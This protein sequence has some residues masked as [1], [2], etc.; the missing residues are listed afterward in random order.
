MRG[1]SG[2]PNDHC[3]ADLLFFPDFRFKGLFAAG[4]SVGPFY[5]EMPPNRPKWANTGIKGTHGRI[6]QRNRVRTMNKKGKTKIN[7]TRDD[8]RVNFYL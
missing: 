2:F 5:R 3:P 8:S 1:C 6:S 7:K 4:W